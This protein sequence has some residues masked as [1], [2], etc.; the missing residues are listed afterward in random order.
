[1][2][3]KIRIYPYIIEGT[4]DFSIANRAIT[5]AFA[6]RFNA[7]IANK[8]IIG[9]MELSVLID[10][11]FHGDRRMTLEVGSSEKMVEIPR[12]QFRFA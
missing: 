3:E 8:V 9:G 5:A 11:L 1:M 4:A 7:E 2:A 12:Y 6:K 10:P